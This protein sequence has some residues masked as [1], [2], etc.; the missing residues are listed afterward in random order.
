MRS[1][2]EDEGEGEGKVE[3]AG[4][5]PVAWAHRMQF[6]HAVACE[7]KRQRGVVQQ[8]ASHTRACMY[9]CMDTY[10]RLYA[11]VRIRM[12]MYVRTCACTHV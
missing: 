6:S 1:E 12:C 2:G 11:C 10:T 7:K 9:A 3:A 8:A 4:G 5:A